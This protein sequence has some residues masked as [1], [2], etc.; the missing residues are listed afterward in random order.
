MSDLFETKGGPEYP[1]TENIRWA[2][3]SLRDYF[4]GQAL[5]GYLADMEDMSPTGIDI[6]VERCYKF[7]DA[8]LKAR[9][10]K[11]DGS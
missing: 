3:M 6:T 10:K 1:N 4:A 8:M 7:A 5:A 2:G 9:E 11:V